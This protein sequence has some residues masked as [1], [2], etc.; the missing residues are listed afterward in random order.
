MGE[1]PTQVQ[2]P[3]A[4]I[5]LAILTEVLS[6]LRWLVMTPMIL[7]YG[8]VTLLV[9]I[10][11]WSFLSPSLMLPLVVA[12]YFPQGI[13]LDA[14]EIEA[15]F[16]RGWFIFSLFLHFAHKIIEAVTH[17]KIVVG[18][19]KR[20]GIQLLVLTGLYAILIISAYAHAGWFTK[21][22]GDVPSGFMLFYAGTAAITIVSWLILGLFDM[23]LS[24]IHAELQAK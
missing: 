18:F 9:L 21:Q 15:L 11:F 17:K 2:T 12:K 6:Y 20:I 8:I 4:R 14:N 7:T 3:V 23:I 24:G 5:L 13:H 22:S 1:D 10:T 16:F 19:F